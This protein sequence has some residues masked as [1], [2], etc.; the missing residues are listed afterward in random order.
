MD[1]ALYRAHAELETTHWWFVGR[2]AIIAAVL[3]RRLGPVAP[4]PVLDLGSGTG[5]MLP[6]LARYGEVTAVESEAYAVDH[7]RRQPVA[8]TVIHGG[9]PEDVPP[10]GDY[11]L[12]T[13]FDVIE[14]LDDDV[15]ALR[16]MK[17]AAR[18]DGAVVVTVPALSWLWSEHDVANHHRRRYSRRGLLD[19]MGRA[20]LD[21]RHVSYF[22]SALLPAVAAVRLAG[23]LR[24]S[25]PQGRSDFEM[26]LPPK[27]ANRALSVLLASERSLVAGPG[28]PIGVSLIALA[29]AGR[30]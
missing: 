27:M 12:V 11:R 17:A 1:P 23:R 9:I 30:P 15:G 20:G 19:V 13:A 7:A 10:S 6:L 14:H 5:G 4:G 3:D 21:V 16:A 2:R 24:R 28:L 29:A 26:G 22:N 25:R 8:A 18:P